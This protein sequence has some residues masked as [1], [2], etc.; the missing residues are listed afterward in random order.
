[1]AEIIAPERGQRGGGPGLSYWLG[2]KIVNQPLM[3]DEGFAGHLQ[4][5][6]KTNA[7]DA[8][9]MPDVSGSKFVGTRDISSRYR[10]TDDGIAIV[11]VSGVLLDRGDWLGDMWGWATSYEGLAEQFRRLAKDSAI[12]SV[13]LDID[14]GGGMVAGCFD[15]CAEM[16]KLKKTK[17]VYAIAANMSA[18]AAY[19][20][21][22]VAHEL[23]VTR[24]GLV[25]SIGVIAMHTSYQRL[26]DQAGIDTT[27][28]CRGSHKGDGNP[29]QQLA[30]GARSEMA[31]SIDRTFEQFV[32]HVAKHR[33]I[34]AADV[35]EM[36]SRVYSG[37]LAVSA[38]L[39]DG[40]KNFEELLDHIRKGATSS[41]TAPKKGGRT[42]SDNNAPAAARLDIEGAIAA[43]TAGQRSV[44][45][46]AAAPAAHPQAAA[47]AAPTAAAAAPAAV[48]AETRIFAILDC[49]EAKER[50]A[51]ARTLA[52][53][54]KLSV[55]EA[56]DI[57]AASA[58]EKPAATDD[59]A[60]LAA[61][62]QAQM[63]KPGNSAA[64]KPDAS[65]DAAQ[66]PSLAD[67][68][69]ARYGARAAQQGVN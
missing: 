34:D 2:T 62:L 27:I 67:K 53:N 21:G 55:D 69:K 5:A 8:Q 58:V 59:K 26:L 41:S 14:S 49:D 36:E 46:A 18:S 10:V 61:S 37:Q 65:G 39:A 54:A 63:Q 32:A 31:A 22:C 44:A 6:L 66:R 24:N 28:I 51:L 60:Q 4:Q 48:N 29:Y 7:F 3:M 12:K 15:L 38:G 19:A 13:V 16:A 47:P 33:E 45:P 30:H 23:F 56:K 1:M 20:I 50:P 35:S 43:Y 64:I 25:G 57:L 40:V 11:P 42:V 17:R 9:F 52:R 68:V